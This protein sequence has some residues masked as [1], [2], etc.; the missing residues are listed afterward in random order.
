MPFSR[1]LPRPSPRAT[2]RPTQAGFSPAVLFA[3][4]EKGAWYDFSNWASVFTD[5]ARTVPVTASGQQAAGVT[6]LSGNGLH[7][8]QATTAARPTFTVG[9]NGRA[10][11]SF[12]GIDDLIF[13]S[14]NMDLATSEVT[15]VAAIRKTSDAATG[16]VLEHGVNTSTDLGTFA[17][18]APN[19]AANNVAFQIIGATTLTAATASGLVAP[20]NC[21]V[22]ATGN[23]GTLRTI[24]VNNGVPVPNGTN[25]GGGNFAARP[26]HVGARAGG[27]LRFVGT[28]TEII[29]RAG[30]LSDADLATIYRYLAAKQG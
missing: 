7:L 16:V 10:A 21:I 23:T 12:D 9:A 1:P 20:L 14:A 13:S 26:L 25:G 2:R 11:L 19:G 18:R 15:F 6:D 8:S 27:S 4:G 17:I 3:R 24:R 29:I 5:T 30:I 28:I 22:V